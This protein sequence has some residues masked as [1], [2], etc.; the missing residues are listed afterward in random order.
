MTKSDNEQSENLISLMGD[1]FLTLAKNDKHSRVD[2]HVRGS[3]DSPQDS[4]KDLTELYDLSETYN[5]ACIYI[6]SEGGRID[7]LMELVNVLGKF[8]SVITVVTSNASS[9]AFMLWSI[10]DVRVV[11]P[12]AE[13]MVHRETSGYIDKTYPMHDRVTF[14]KRRFDKLFV[15]LCND[16]LTEEEL[17]EAK[18]GELWFLGEDFIERGNAISWETFIERDQQNVDVLPILTLDERMYAEIGGMF[19][20]VESIELNE[21][22]AYRPL[23]IIYAVPKVQSLMS[24]ELNGNY[25]VEENKNEDVDN[26]LSLVYITDI[27]QVR[28]L[29]REAFGPGNFSVEMRYMDEH[30]KDCNFA[31]VYGI[32]DNRKV[33]IFADSTYQILNYYT[34]QY[35]IELIN[36]A[37]EDSQGKQ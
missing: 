4:T 25:A 29:L 33:R 14:L 17:E 30:G 34:V 27:D 32:L 15:D 2:I 35:V 23:D 6:N 11:C 31:R 3:F 18:R 7:T 8:D 9:A 37:I 5:T 12:S 16:I 19:I 24:S 13:L 26:T 1:R 22:E 10:G 36:E 21:N 20:P 28:D